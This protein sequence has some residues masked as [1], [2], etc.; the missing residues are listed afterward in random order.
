MGHSDQPAL[1]FQQIKSE[2]AHVA[3]RDLIKNKPDS[4]WQMG[5]GL[6]QSLGY[7]GSF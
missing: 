1:R 5:D 3:F 4:T 7:G 2:I 6:R